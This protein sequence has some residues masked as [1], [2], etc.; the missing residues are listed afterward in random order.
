MD[1]SDVTINPTP[2]TAG[3]K[4]TVKY[5]GMLSNS[6]ANEVY[7]HAGVGFNDEWKDVTDIQMKPSASGEWTTQLRVNTAE[8]FNFCFKDSA[9]NWDNNNG[10]NWS[11]EIHNGEL[12]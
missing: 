12:Y 4:I 3:E 10:Q 5:D 9:E 7:L 8:R 6:G 2:V 1:H 11:L